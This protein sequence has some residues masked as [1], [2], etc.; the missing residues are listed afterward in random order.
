M[1]VDGDKLT[2]NMTDNLKKNDGIVFFENSADGDF[3]IP[4]VLPTI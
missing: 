4:V 1:K 3:D 2:K